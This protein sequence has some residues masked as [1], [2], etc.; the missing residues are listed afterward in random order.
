ME[1]Q[2]TL[3]AK[4][5]SA[6]QSTAPSEEPSIE[7][8][9][10]L[11]YQIRRRRAKLHA[12]DSVRPIGQTNYTLNVESLLEPA[13][14]VSLHLERLTTLLTAIFQSASLTTIARPAASSTPQYVTL[15]QAAA[16]VKL[17][18]KTVGRAL[19][20]DPKAPTPDR[21]GG[22]GKCSYW[23]WHRIRPWLEQQ[24]GLELPQFLPTD[25][26]G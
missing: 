26:P 11:M 7:E 15:D 18:K 5:I 13:E 24:Y 9:K 16:W 14:R 8:R 19:N 2:C 17:H 6:D 23:K 25:P 4:A 1:P 22:G 12:K 10:E 20:S 3:A 21:E